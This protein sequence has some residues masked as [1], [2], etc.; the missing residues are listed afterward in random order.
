MDR[1]MRT[2]EL[3]A[4]AI[5]L[6][7][8]VPA[9]AE[10]ARWAWHVVRPGDTLEGIT[11]RYLGSSQRWRENWALNK[12]IED[13]DFL[14]PGQRVR[15]LLPL[16]WPSDTALLDTVSRRVEEQ[17]VPINWQDARA[18]DL[19]RRRDAVRTG[20]GSSAQLRFA[21]GTSV[22]VSEDSLLFLRAHHADEPAPEPAPRG[23]EIVAG[24]A[25]VSR[26]ATTTADASTPPPAGIEIVVGPAAARPAN[27]DAALRARARRPAAGGAEVM[28]YEGAARVE[29][30][31]A[32]VD[33]PQGSGTV[34]AETG[35]PAAPQPLLS[36]PEL[37]FPAVGADLRVS[38]PR[39]SWTPVAGATSYTLELC[40]DDSCAS[41][42]HREMRLAEASWHAAQLVPGAMFWRVT[43]VASNGLD[44]YPS[45]T[46]PLT[47]SGTGI[48]SAPAAGQIV[49]DGTQVMLGDTLVLGPGAT[50]HVE[51]AKSGGTIA[52]ALD[53]ATAPAER[54][55]EGW[56]NGP[57]V[58]SATVTDPSGLAGE[59]TPLAF[60]ADR[61][62][63]RL[64]YEPTPAEA[65]RTQ[66]LDAGFSEPEPPSH[67]VRVDADAP[68]VWSTHG[69]D[70]RA[71]LPKG[72]RTAEWT[73]DADLPAVFIEAKRSLRLTG[74]REITVRAGQI[75]KISARDELS[76]VRRLR[77]LAERTATGGD[78]T[79][80]A[81]DLLG[82]TVTSR[83][84]VAPGG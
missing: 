12:D 47:I 24:Q 41:L 64:S 84:H 19:L 39:F 44:G 70:W 81:T 28:L 53:G 68:L 6:A 51:G 18:Q 63:P 60:V 61:V 7:L 55:G 29:A 36:A 11:E 16:R 52:L 14:L 66:G 78:L 5:L 9:V 72:E 4:G 65:L 83:W 1:N 75:V 42:L 79:V 45:A 25:E 54:W 26:G 33:V 17:P 27:E 58:A 48:A 10:T 8:A 22:A 74:E 32:A 2:R 34:V 23:V 56:E 43:A 46:R 21:D 69:L 82:N 13:P 50:I 38:N 35:P 49:A 30:A 77:L 73:V 59:V 57:H 71:L 15:V 31:G 67:Y 3:I 80:E 62:P 20:T 40:A 37:A 76:A